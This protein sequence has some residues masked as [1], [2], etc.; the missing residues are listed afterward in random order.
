MPPDQRNPKFLWDMLEA[1]RT[2]QVFVKDRTRVEY[3][4][5]L[6]L[7]LAI[8]RA[9]EIVGEACRGVSREFRVAHPEVPWQKI[10]TTRNILAHEYGGIDNDVMWRIA[11]IHLPELILLLEPLIP[12]LES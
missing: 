8:E 1:A 10:T 4:D 7:R 3:Q 9:V 2:V 6:M 12:T 11:T 5:D